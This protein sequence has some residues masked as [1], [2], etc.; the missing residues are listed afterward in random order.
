MAHGNPGADGG[1]Y[2]DGLHD[3][4]R[5]L[6]KVWLAGGE[7]LL[8]YRCGSSTESASRPLSMDH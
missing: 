6:H 1:E 5:G 8:V 3:C 2:A 7:I 4:H